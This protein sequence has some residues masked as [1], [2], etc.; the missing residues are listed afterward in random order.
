MASWWQYV[1]FY[2]GFK[3]TQKQMKRDQQLEPV[4]DELAL[5]EDMEIL[6]N[7]Y[8]SFEYELFHP[9]TLTLDVESISGHVLNVAVVDKQNLA[10]IEG[11][12]VSSAESALHAITDRQERLQGNLPAGEWTVIVYNTNES[13]AAAAYLNVQITESGTASSGVRTSDKRPVLAGTLSLLMPGAGQLYNGQVLKSVA[14]FFAVPVTYGVCALL[15]AAA[16]FS[17]LILLGVVVQIGVIYD[18]Y[19]TSKAP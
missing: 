1:L 14:A 6:P 9:A 7:R 15:A 4:T 19:A 11:G 18:A 10:R 13:E 16:G 8:H 12:A 17:L 5:T 2:V 3:Q